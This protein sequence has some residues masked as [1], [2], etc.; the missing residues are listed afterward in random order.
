MEDF[1]LNN[2]VALQVESTHLKEAPG[3][4]VTI[5]LILHN[6]SPADEVFELSV[7]GVAS[8]WVSTPS[9]VIRLAAGEQRE[10]LVTI[11]APA[12]P[13]GRA[14]R[15]HVVIRAAK[16]GA[17]QPQPRRAWNG[18]RP[19]N[20]R[21]CSLQSHRQSNPPNLHRSQRLQNLPRKS[22]RRPSSSRPSQKKGACLAPPWLLD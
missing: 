13:M 5:P 8:N 14:G 16:P 15:H 1:S 17:P 18:Q 10:L 19:R 22:H 3:S 6:H 12:P 11:Q 2:Q 20:R 9:P 4:S 21:Q 7:R